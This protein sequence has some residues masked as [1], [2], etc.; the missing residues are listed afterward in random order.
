MEKSVLEEKAIHTLQQHEIFESDFQCLDNDSDEGYEEFDKFCENLEQRLYNE[1]NNENIKDF[2][3]NYN[4]HAFQE[5][6]GSLITSDEF[7]SELIELAKK[8]VFIT[9]NVHNDALGKP[10]SVVLKYGSQERKFDISDTTRAVREIIEN[11]LT[12][13]Y[14]IEGAHA[15]VRTTISKMDDAETISER[16][17]L[18]DQFNQKWNGQLTLKYETMLKDNYIYRKYVVTNVLGEVFSS[19]DQQCDTKYSKIRFFNDEH[20]LLT[21]P[22]KQGDKASAYNCSRFFKVA[23]VTA[24]GVAATAGMVKLVMS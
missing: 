23:A 6:L 20:S 14:D 19:C 2:V 3:E 16:Q 17:W 22:V 13:R 7:N 5:K 4:I 1:N 18:S 9:V 24:V 10:L 21:A 15:D 12:Y 8:N 11:Q